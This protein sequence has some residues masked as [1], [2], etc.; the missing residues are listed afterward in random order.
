MKLPNQEQQESIERIIHSRFYDRIKVY[1]VY[2][3]LSNFEDEEMDDAIELMSHIM[4]F[5]ESD[6]VGM[7]TD[8]LRLL[9]K[10]IDKENLL[11]YFMAL[12]EPGKSGDA[13][14]YLIQKIVKS[15]LDTQ[16]QRNVKFIRSVREIDIA[17]C[18]SKKDVFVILLD[19]IIGSG[20][21]FQKF[22]NDNKGK[23]GKDLL[24]I[25]N[26]NFIKTVLMVP[27]ILELGKTKIM[28]DYPNV[29]IKC[30]ETY[31]K[32]F[33]KGESVLGGYLTILRLRTFC[34]KYGVQLYK[35]HPLGWNNSQALV[36]FE[37]SAPNNT[38]PIIWSNTWVKRYNRYW[39]P[40]FPRSYKKVSEQSFS[41]RTEN[42][43][44]V[45]MLAKKM[46]LSTVDDLK[47]HFTVDNYNLVLMFCMLMEH[48]PD[49]RI[50]NIL[51]MTLADIDILYK[52]G[53]DK[54]WDKNHKIICDA[55]NAYNEIKKEISYKR[56]EAKCQNP[57]IIDDR[58]YMYIPGTFKG[59]K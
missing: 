22:I 13:M 50:A 15:N 9:L 24:P 39:I 35:K 33:E 7:L 44:W 10:G 34:Y 46:N 43:R 42:N 58:D 19:D 16:I 21:S 31:H 54:F 18:K 41:N 27:V 17:P 52:K 45:T 51:C 59:L 55:K 47:K 48:V 37:H 57:K 8:S 40:L 49:F 32:V 11:V 23:A 25:I 5:R 3:W 36:V 2:Q 20:D 6:L 26:N 29:I 38:L 56:T 1:D 30:N 14:M 12:G 53:E 4:Y 28:K